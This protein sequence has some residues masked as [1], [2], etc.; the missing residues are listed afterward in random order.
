LCERNELALRGANLWGFLIPQQVLKET[1]VLLLGNFP[2][3][4][5]LLHHKTPLLLQEMS[6]LDRDMVFWC[7]H[8]KMVLRNIK[9]CVAIRIRGA[10]PSSLV[11]G[12]VTWHGET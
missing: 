9:N 3:L 12:I 6:I 10:S 8:S 7:E 1:Y 4:Q 5:K 11:S 2:D